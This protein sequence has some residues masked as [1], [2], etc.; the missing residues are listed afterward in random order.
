MLAQALVDVRLRRLV[1]SLV[2]AR[3]RYREVHVLTFPVPPS[4]T[5]TSLKVGFCCS[6]MLG[7]V[8]TRKGADVLCG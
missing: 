8:L 7:F 3:P 5:R 4:P 1:R 6:A 2:V